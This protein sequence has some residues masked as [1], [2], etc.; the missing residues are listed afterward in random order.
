MIIIHIRMQVKGGFSKTIDFLKKNSKQNVRHILEAGG[1]RG[2]EALRSATPTRSGKTA[3]AWSYEIENT[4]NG[5]KIVWRNT[6]VNK[7]HNIAILLQYGH[8][9]GTG[10]YVQG[11]DYIN[12][13]MKPVF[14]SL[15][16][17]LMEE[18]NK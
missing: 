12:P 10:G 16:K 7:G 1:K 15:A 9:T 8:G 6:N 13:A 11:I 5:Y 4:G 18:V 14:E 2:V 3:N 17:E